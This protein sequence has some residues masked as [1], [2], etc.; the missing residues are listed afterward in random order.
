LYGL[1]QCPLLQKEFGKT[2]FSKACGHWREE[3]SMQFRKLYKE[4]FCG[5]KMLLSIVSSG[6]SRWLRWIVM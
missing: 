1:K 5:L 6:K 3:V 4:E 2:A